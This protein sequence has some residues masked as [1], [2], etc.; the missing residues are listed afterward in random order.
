MNAIA[1]AAYLALFGADAATT[2]QA[3]ARGGHEMFL[4]QSS[5]LNDVLM[6]GQASALWWATGK[7]HRP[8]LRWTLRLA[9]AGAHGAA[10][11]HNLQTLRRLQ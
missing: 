4:T 7:I 1:L 8:A 9:I 3:I 5:A 2:H 11:A 6:A 10:A